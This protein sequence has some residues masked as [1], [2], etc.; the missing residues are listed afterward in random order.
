MPNIDLIP[1]VLYEA[2]QPYHYYYDNLPL[3]NILDRQQ[4]INFAV[5][6]N[7]KLLREAIGTQG[8]LANR[9]A[10]SIEDDGSLKT[11]AVDAALHSIAEHTD[12]DAFVRMTKN[13]RDK[14]GLVS[15]GATALQMLFETTAGDVSFSDEQVIFADS[16]T[17][18]W[19]AEAPNV[20]RART[21]FPTTAV[22]RHVYEATPVRA[23]T[24]TDYH[25]WK[26]TSI[27][28]V[29]VEG[30]LRV[31]ING[32]RIFSDVD[33]SVP[34][35]TYTTW[36]AIHFTPNHTN[37]TFELSRDITSSDKIKIDFDLDLNS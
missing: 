34:D 24:G 11:V 31:Y 33:V 16:N 26:V 1:E 37:G 13:E 12:T 17:I 7:S 18:V 28:T 35:A 23:G 36:T 15:A 2:M 27:N 6:N 25:N 8:T 29:F 4:L 21:A 32:A 30:S 19:E 14:L 10:Q 20:V 3:R 22:H 5:D 9:L